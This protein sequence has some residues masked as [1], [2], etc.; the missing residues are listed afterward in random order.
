MNNLKY[1]IELNAKG[2]LIPELKIVKQQMDRVTGSVKSATGKFREMGSAFSRLSSVNLVS[3]TSN[4]KGM[5]EAINGISNASL[6]MGFQQAMAD[7]KAITGIAGK[8]FDTLADSA[9][10][11]GRET[12]LGAQ[13]A[14]EAYTL[15][16]SQIQIDRF[17]FIFALCDRA[18]SNA[19]DKITNYS[20]CFSSLF[21]VTLYTQ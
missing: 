7:L 5:F 18:D 14:V 8:D 15:L 1:T 21:I 13:G 19:L 20:D 10:K 16:A 2:K 12:G 4:L 17:G 11:V 9:R 3:I 6:G